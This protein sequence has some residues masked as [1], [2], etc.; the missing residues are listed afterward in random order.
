MSPAIR[1][2][3]AAAIGPDVPRYRYTEAL[4]A[5]FTT[6]TIVWIEDADGAVGMGGFDGDS[7]EDFDLAA[8]ETIRS[9][10]RPLLGRDADDRE[11]VF[12]DLRWGGV[13]PFAPGP[14]GAIDVA[15]WDLAARVAEQPLF[16]F[17]GGE[18]DR[19]PAYASVPTLSGIDDYLAVLAEVVAAGLGAAKLHASGD[20]IRDAQ[21]HRV[22]HEHHPELALIHDAEGVYDLDGALAVGRVLDET[23]CRWY[24][25]PLSDFDLPGYRTVRAATAT[26]VLP[27][28]D[29]VWELRQFEEVLRDP[30]WDAIRSE[31]VHIGGVTPAIALSGLAASR[32]LD[33]EWV[34]YGHSLLQAVNLHVSLAFGR[35]T[36]IEQAYPSHAWEFGVIEPIR[37][38]ASG[39]VHAPTGPGLGLDLDADA[40]AAATIAAFEVS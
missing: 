32:D 15:L 8:L 17:L 30:P 12:N 18:L 36:L 6:T 5:R 10:S 31:V 39:I 13:N 35:T 37:P 21:L 25:A 16:R 34:H 2:V 7:F 19:L 29:A 20:P 24:E 28:G 26:P 22:V 11:G 3:S 38:D 40:I 9:A 23:E 33:I 27:A 4:P 1:R 14:L